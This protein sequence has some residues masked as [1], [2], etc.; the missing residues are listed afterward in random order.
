MKFFIASP[1][2][3]KVAVKELEDALIL[4]GHAPWSFLD[5]GANLATGE[6]V[7]EEFKQFGQSMTNW[8][9]DSMIGHIFASEMRNLKDCDALI[10]LEPAGRSSLAEAGIAYGM[11]KRII[12]IG[13]VEHP[14]VVYLICERSYP[15][16]AAFLKDI[17][18]CPPPYHRKNFAVNRCDLRKIRS[19]FHLVEIRTPNYSKK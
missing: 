5:D 13:S 2:R 19:D 3:N 14:E 15:N 4:R 16:V 1:W 8:K 17:Y 11:G 6:G 10:L 7:M 12:L 9:D 18:P